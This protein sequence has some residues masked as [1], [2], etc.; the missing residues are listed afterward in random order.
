MKMSERDRQAFEALVRRLAPTPLPTVLARVVESPPTSAGT[1]DALR[2]RYVVAVQVLGPD[3]SDDL[4]WPVLH[5]VPVSH[6]WAGQGTGVW[7]LPAEGSIVRLDW[8]YGD[9]CRPCVVGIVQ[10]GQDVPEHAQGELIVT[11]GGQVRLR[12]LSD[13]TV[14]LG[15]GVQLPSGVVRQCDVCALT[16]V[17]HAAASQEVKAR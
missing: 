4:E 14:E 15:G 16:G 6:L 7:A 8:D 3:G 1:A 5:E 13:G 12:I 11:Q 9:A 17:G 10:D 2:P